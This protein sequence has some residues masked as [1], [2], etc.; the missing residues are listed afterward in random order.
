MLGYYGNFRKEFCNSYFLK[1]HKANKHGI[2][3]E[4]DVSENGSEGRQTTPTQASP[5]TAKPVILSLEDKYRKV[6]I[7]PDVTPRLC[8]LLTFL[9][10][11]YMELCCIH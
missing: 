11:E 6:R 1:V 5:P 7:H 4:M 10:L 2:H 3:E 9:R 8:T